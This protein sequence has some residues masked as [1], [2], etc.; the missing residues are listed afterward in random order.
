MR[1]ALLLYGRVKYFKNQY[2]NII[3]TIGNEHTIDIF[4]S[5]D[6]ELNTDISEFKE[7][8]KPI[9]INNNNIYH[10][11]DFNKYPI[12]EPITVTIDNFIR[13]FINLKRVFK[14][15][16][17]YINET[18][19]VY[20]IVIT[21]RIDLCLNVRLNISNPDNNTIYIPSG[22]DH[23]T[24]RYPGINDRFAMGNIDV[25]RQYNTIIDNCIYL[26]ENKMSYPHPE[27]LT[28]AHII[29][30]KINIIRFESR[31]MSVLIRDMPN[32]KCH[33]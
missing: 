9:S 33:S 18:G 29:F 14:L 20:D 5:S 2:E 7:L 12:D 32:V 1:I 26:L 6:N 10:S 27:M 23:G 31:E 17:E 4:L 15:L 28:Y 3:N 16:E 11:Y 22:H 24:I 8:Y 21:T 30:S 13:H 19:N 25:M